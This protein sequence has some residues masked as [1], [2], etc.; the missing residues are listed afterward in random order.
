MKQQGVNQYKLDLANVNP[1]TTRIIG[2][3]GYNKR[4]LEIGCA[5]GYVSEYLSRQRDCVVTGVE[6]EPDAASIAGQFCEKV[7]V[8]DIENDEV[9]KQ[10]TGNYDVIILADILEHLRNPTR[11][12]IALRDKLLPDGFILISLPNVAHYSVRFKLLLGKFEYTDGGL[13]DKTHLRF[14][15]LKSAR[16]M[17]HEA[18]YTIEH[19]DMNMSYTYLGRFLGRMP[20]FYRVVLSLMKIAP[21][22][23]GYQFFFKLKPC[24]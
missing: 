9:L 7:I 5:S 11:V 17:I 21:N 3:V 20:R 24:N 1:S 8:G 23:F 10:I 4:V 2:L 22:F 6:I 19:F 18:G 13:L 12:L 15:T 14:F 16:R